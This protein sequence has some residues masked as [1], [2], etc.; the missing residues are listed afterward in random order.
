[1]ETHVPAYSHDQ[2]T[3]SRLLQDR[4]PDPRI[5]RLVAQAFRQSGILRRHTVMESFFDCA[6]FDA[7]GQADT[8]ARNTVYAVEARRLATALGEKLLSGPS[9]IPRERI[10]HLIFATC[11]G[12]VNPGPDYYLVRDLGLRDTVERYTLGFMGCYAAFPALRMAAQ[13][14]SADPK[15]AVLVVS[16]ELCSLH[17]QIEA[18]TDDILGNT[19]FADG[20]AGA[21]VT[22]RPAAG[23]PRC[24]L[25]QFRSATIPGGESA[26]AWTIGNRGF[27]LV[28]S[29]YVPKVLAME[30]RGLFDRLGIDPA[31]Y[32]KFAVHPGGKSILD[33]VASALDLPEDGLEASRQVLRDYGN[34]SSATI[35]FVLRALLDAGEPGDRILAF[36]FGPGLTVE[37]AELEV[38]S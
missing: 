33:R 16:V 32:G 13:F 38:L 21:I 20:A 30:I 4:F 28:L 37:T 1:M 3:L 25:G 10:T 9:A 12:F 7:S 11:T 6:P 23:E 36:A 2:A 8:A 5:R 31:D 19:V 24:R 27:D 26:M 15:A 29:S 18:S 14:C 22:S 35:L 34:M 17:M